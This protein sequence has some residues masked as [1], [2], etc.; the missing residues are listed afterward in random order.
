MREPLRRNPGWLAGL[1]GAAAA[2]GLTGF[3][4][5][6]DSDPGKSGGSGGTGQTGQCL[7]TREYF[8]EKVW[9]PVMA[10]H[11]LKC[12]APDGEAV[13]E[14]AKFQLLPASY[15]GFLDANLE[16]AKKFAKTQYD[17]KSYLLFKPLGDIDHGGGVVFEAGSPEHQALESFVKNLPATEACAGGGSAMSFD[18]VV[19]LDA[20]STLRKASITL[21][22]RLPKPAEIEKVVTEGEAALSAVLLE[23]M[24]EDA[25]FDRIKEIF[26][27]VY[28]TDRYL[29]YSSYAAN[30]LNKT[31]FPNA[32]DAWF[33]TLPTADQTKVNRALAREPLELVAHIVKND[34]P[35]SEVVT[36]DYTVMNY[37]SAKIYNAD[38]NG[39]S[40]TDE[41]D[42]QERKIVALGEGTIP[43]AG[44]LTSPVWLN[45]FPTTP[46]NRNRHRSRMI[47]KFFLATDIL[48]VAERPLDPTAATAVQNP[49]MNDQSCSVCHRMIDPIA[50]A[51]QKYDDNDQEKF[52]PKNTWHNDMVLSGFGGEVM[53]NKDYDAAL[54]WLGAR[55]V[56]DPRF[57][58]S[59]VY[60]MYT[61]LTGQEPL[62]YPRSADSPTLKQELAAWTAQDAMF[63]RIADTFVKEGQNLKLVVR[64]IVL[65][66]YFRGKN[67]KAALSEG[68]AAE[69]AG[70]GTGR[71]I[72]PEVLGRKIRAVTGL[73][74]GKGVGYYKTD[75][76]SSD[77][78]ILY[79]GIDSDDVT[80]RLS[81]PNGVMAN[82]GWR[83]ANEV[84]CQTTAWDLSVDDP[85]A[86]F[87]FPYVEVADTPD[88][89]AAAIKKNIQYL[90]A[91][92]L[93]EALPLGDAELDKTY[94]L[95]VDT[96]N[97]GKAAIAA[98]TLT[99]DIVYSCRARK[100]PYTDQDLPTAE[101]LEKDPDYT[102][103]AWM[104]VVTYL[105]SDFHF[106]Y[107]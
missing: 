41:T 66:P 59:V 69:L 67:T 4:C 94:Q 8:A 60:T 65:S 57:S 1:L 13:M 9:A 32:G 29:G 12:H 104:A 50:G 27:D 35:F 31:Q 68:R 96:W 49:T 30:L 98:K 3:G 53:E 33:E 99:A 91:H 58:L 107:E 92:V 25:F 102:V 44:V 88:T 18:D 89:S 64:D 100:N 105:M 46:T 70:V 16:M 78:R 2:A 20:L 86:R 75:Y 23:M 79:G 14:G 83:M 85:A 71:L 61:A 26:N 82:V 21:L 37:F 45:R 40:Q 74:W 77:Y 73:P 22:G 24:K 10:E 6:S 48:K 17:G 51:F 106:L 47:F 90:H 54:P 103:R 11:C 36:A 5:S 43:H 38:L 93:G 56:A 80:K 7:S 19:Q 63:R 95:F 72:I 81:A 87:L 101:R 42:F 34:K 97:E 76:L 62:E 55:I 15:P 52:E 84:A 39:L 28:L